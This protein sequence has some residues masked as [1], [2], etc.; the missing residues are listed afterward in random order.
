ML[1]EVPPNQGEII[2]EHL[3]EEML[4]EAVELHLSETD[5]ITLLDFL[6]A[7]LSEDADDVEDI[8]WVPILC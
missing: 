7:L 5:T 8:K 1:L 4:D 2:E 6:S 3:T